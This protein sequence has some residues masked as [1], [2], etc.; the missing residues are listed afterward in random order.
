MLIPSFWV[1]PDIGP[2]FPTTSPCTGHRKLRPDRGGGG[3]SE[4]DAVWSGGGGVGCTVTVAGGG[5][6]GPD[7]CACWAGAV[8][9]GGG[10]NGAAVIPLEPPADCGGDGRAV[11]GGPGSLGVDAA[12]TGGSTCPAVWLGGGSGVATMLAEYP[13]EE[14]ACGGSTSTV[15]E[16]IV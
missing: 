1:P 6:L 14:A 5:A 11:G 2:N 12:E 15:P 16:K 7:A 8:T 4:R 9:L 3:G 13:P 10:T